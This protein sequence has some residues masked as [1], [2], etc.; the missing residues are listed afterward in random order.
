M[1]SVGFARHFS[2]MP[3]HRRLDAV[4]CMRGT[5][6]LASCFIFPIY[7]RSLAA[8][9][10]SIEQVGSIVSLPDIVKAYCVNKNTVEGTAL[11]LTHSVRFLKSCFS[12]MGTKLAPLFL[13]LLQVIE[14]TGRMLS[15]WVEESKLARA[16]DLHQRAARGEEIPGSYTRETYLLTKKIE[17][18][19]YIAGIGALIVP[20]LVFSSAYG[21]QIAVISE[22]SYAA[23]CLMHYFYKAHAQGY[24]YSGPASD[25]GGGGDDG[26]PSFGGKGGKGKPHQPREM[27]RSLAPGEDP[28]KHLR[29]SHQADEDMVVVEPTDSVMNQG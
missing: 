24:N 9:L 29:E 2:E 18:A 17:I 1:V 12:G 26:A 10:Y 14:S 7:L 19:M 8:H 21:A 27:T 13:D 4:T 23:L 15:T 5:A 28:G 16:Y 20:F 11:T 3:F 6:V 22:V 25:D